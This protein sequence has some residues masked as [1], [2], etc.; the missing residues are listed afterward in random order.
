M[1]EAPEPLNRLTPQE[2]EA[3]RLELRRLD[4]ALELA[5]TRTPIRALDLRTVK[6]MRR[7]RDACRQRLGLR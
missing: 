1:K 3:I 5:Q 7:E 6:I 2:R 4:A